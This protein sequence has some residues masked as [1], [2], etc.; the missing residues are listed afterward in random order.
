MEIIYEVFYAKIFLAAFT[1]SFLYSCA[2]AVAPGVSDPIVPTVTATLTLT[3]SSD[4]AIKTEITATLSVAMNPAT[5]VAV[6]FTVKNGA[7]AVAGVVS[8]DTATNKATFVP[9]VN[10]DT[11]TLYTATLTTSA[12]TVTGAGLAA[13]KIWSFTARTQTAFGPSAVNLGTA[14]NFV[15]LAKSGIDT[16]PGS[17][18]TGDIGVSPAAATFITGFSLIADSTN[19]F[20]TSSQVVGKVYAASYAVPSPAQMTTAI[21][22]METAY[23]D[24]AGRVTPDFVELY[25]GDISGK[26]LKAGLY[27]WGTG[28]LIN[29][30]VTLSGGASDVWIFQIVGDL[31]QANA[32][33]IVLTGGAKPA[34]IFWQA[35]GSVS[36]GTTSHLEGVLLSKTNIA[37]NT[38]ATMNG[39]LLAQTAVTLKSN[40]V[41]KP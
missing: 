26:T 34:N 2:P 29:T 13:D 21:S 8:Y 33:K 20:S 39:R 36:L 16:I 11:S 27:K 1:V 17:T 10:L 9:N 7:T 12:A 3:A 15:V 6:N 19:V 35:F 14:G 40:T 37:M 28:V 5:I 25:A 38:G 31:T 32:A 24:A 18:I 30:D 4:I 23:T 22:D 41:T